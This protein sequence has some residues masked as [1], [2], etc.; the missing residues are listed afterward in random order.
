MAQQTINIGTVENDR[1]GD[2]L[3][4]AL[5]KC[6]DN[7][8]ELYDSGR[9]IVCGS[10]QTGCPVL[11]AD[12]PVITNGVTSTG[13]SLDCNPSTNGTIT[14]TSTDYRGL[15]VD[16]EYSDTDNASRLKIIG[17]QSDVTAKTGCGDLLNVVGID[18]K[19]I[20]EY[21]TNAAFSAFGIHG[22]AA[23]SGSSSGYV[24][25]IISES[26]IYNAADSQSITINEA[27]GISTLCNISSYKTSSSIAVSYSYGAW[28]QSY[29]SAR[30]YSACTVS[31]TNNYGILC[32][33]S[34]HQ[35]GS[36]QATITNNYGIAVQDNYSG[37][38]STGTITNHYG[39]YLDSF[40]VATN[41]WGVY[42][43]GAAAKNYFNGPITVGTTAASA[44]VHAVATTEQLRLGYDGSNY[45]SF[46]VSSTGVL[47]LATSANKIA[48]GASRTPASATAAGTAGE[49]CWDAN[50]IYVCTATNTWRRTALSS[51]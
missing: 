13:V 6:N 10:L 1:T 11:I 33:T 43:S 16:V 44:K 45:A 21:G 27:G 48:L 34:C 14:S 47:N 32:D 17:I 5:D 7:F 51:W 38:A 36:G 4:T 3:R 39:L 12:S 40:P 8:D 41:E 29:I 35:E 22:G 23:C 26:Y 24:Y 49:V 19:V 30:N 15:N 50:Y 9:D 31:V 25:S 28:I 2:P 46:T 37:S 20:K 42:V 18:G